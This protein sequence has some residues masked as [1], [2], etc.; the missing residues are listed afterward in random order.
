MLAQQPQG[1]LQT[2]HRNIR[3][4]HK[5]KQQ[6]KTHRIEVIKEHILKMTE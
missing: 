2:Q 5:Y 6:K 4:I 1:Q 3:K